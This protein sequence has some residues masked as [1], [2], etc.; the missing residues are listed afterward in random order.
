[1]LFDC[2]RMR[3]AQLLLQPVT[4][5][6]LNRSVFRQQVHC[7]DAD[8]VRPMVL[9]GAGG[10]RHTLSDVAHRLDGFCTRSHGM[11]N[12]MERGQS[13]HVGRS[14]RRVTV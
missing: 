1:M 5:L 4:D 9:H 12:G 13:V 3:V 10:M 8:R 2:T 6:H 11:S 7:Q 14:T